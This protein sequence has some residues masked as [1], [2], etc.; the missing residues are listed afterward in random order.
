MTDTSLRNLGDAG[1]L[2]SPIGLGLAALGRPGYITLGHGSDVGPNDPASLRDRSHDVLDAAVA[3]GVRYVDTARSYGR[4]EEFLGTWLAMRHRPHADPVVGSKWGY[5]YTAGWEVAAEVHEVKEHTLARL[6]AQV[7]ETIS[8]LGEHLCLY[9]I[10]SA[11]AASGILDDRAVLDRLGSL[12]DSGILVGIT[13]SGPGQSAIV[14][15]AVETE[16][17]GRPLFA[18]IQATWNLLE[19]SAGTALGEAHAAGMGVIVKEALANGRL[20][21]RDRSLDLTPLAQV[22][23]ETDTGIDS[24]AIAAALAQ[25]WATVVLSGAASVEQLSSNLLAQS[26]PAARLGLPSFEEEPD[27]YWAT[28]ARLPWN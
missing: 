25:P 23:A 13:T 22:A 4:A 19:T 12:R 14:R 18:T 16:V 10:H 9:Q 6:E 27:T 26:V 2:V 20:A 7:A 24:V 21:G 17:G 15:R 11:T 8:H 1:P 3:G 5:T 28:R